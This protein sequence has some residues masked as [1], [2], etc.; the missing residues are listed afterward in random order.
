MQE[1]SETE[2][3][4][5]CQEQDLNDNQEK[6]QERKYHVRNRKAREFLDTIRHEAFNA[7]SDES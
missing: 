3:Q 1:E 5:H 4:T 6:S 2:G 7:T